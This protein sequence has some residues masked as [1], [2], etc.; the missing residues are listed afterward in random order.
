MI[1]PKS[2]FLLKKSFQESAPFHVNHSLP[3]AMHL[4][5]VQMKFEQLK[6]QKWQYFDHSRFW[7]N[8]KCNSI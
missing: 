8:S 2:G 1:F 3:R 4:T 7:D 5:T 6:L